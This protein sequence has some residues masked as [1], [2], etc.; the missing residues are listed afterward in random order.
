MK[1][2]STGNVVKWNDQFWVVARD[3]YGDDVMELIP[4]NISNC[5]SHPSRKWPTPETGRV[6]VELVSETIYGWMVQSIMKKVF[7]VKEPLSADGWTPR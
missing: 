2:F 5:T 6:A 4:M 3:R 1:I 7:E